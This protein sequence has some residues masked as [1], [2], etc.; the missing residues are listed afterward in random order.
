VALQ[1]TQGTADVLIRSLRLRNGVELKNAKSRIVFEDDRM[2]LDPFAADLL[3]G[4][5]TGNMLYEGRKKSV[6]VDFTGTNLLLQQWFEQ[7]GSR[8]PL[9]GGPMAVA[10][11]FSATGNSMKALAATV[12][13]PITVR[14]G[15]AVWA[16]QKA[17]DAEALMTNAFASKGASRIDLECVVAVMPFRNG[18]ATADPII[19]FRTGASTL[20]TA[21]SV[22]LRSESLDVSGRV[23]PRSGATLGLAS[24]AGNVKIAGPLRAP[25]M[26]LDPA[27][28]PALVARAGAAIATLGIS[29]VG[30]AM[31]DAAEAK[32]NDPCAI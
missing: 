17:G 26:T 15:T 28:T 14:M 6:K 19:G 23:K 16:S 25:K 21:G 24:I 5:A 27:G 2:H 11:K 10:G 31:V 20:I 8:I 1:G 12:T 18:V 7:R 4:S 3:G 29:A 22:D 32:K 9:T 13:G 30:T